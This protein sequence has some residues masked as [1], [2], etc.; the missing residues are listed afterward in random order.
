MNS[1]R[2][3]STIIKLQA[4]R[5]VG[6]GLHS[7]ACNLANRKEYVKAYDPTLHF[8]HA[9]KGRKIAQWREERGLPERGTEYGPLTDLPDFYHSDGS[10]S[11]LNRGQRR[12]LEEQRRLADRIVFLLDEQKSAKAAYRRQEA[13]RDAERSRRLSRR[14]RAKVGY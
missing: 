8:G 5:I 12:R 4:R 11:A 6:S 1:I 10:P 14:L 9:N 2:C 13:E 7:S 3:G